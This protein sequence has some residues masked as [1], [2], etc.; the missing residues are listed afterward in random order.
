MATFIDILEQGQVPI[1]LSID[2]MR[3]LH[4]T[5]EHT[6]Q[7]DK[8]TCKA[9]GMIRQPIPVSSS[10][11]AMF[12]LAAFCKQHDARTANKA[13]DDDK[14]NPIAYPSLLAAAY[15][16]EAASKEPLVPAPAPAAEVTETIGHVNNDH[17]IINRTTKELHRVHVSKRTSKTCPVAN[18]QI[19]NQRVT[20]RFH[21]E[22]KETLSS[23]EDNF[24]FSD[25]PLTAEQIHTDKPADRIIPAPGRHAAEPRDP[26]QPHGASADAPAPA[27]PPVT[28]PLALRRIHT[29]LSQPEELRKLHLQHH[30][31]SAE[32]FKFRT[33][34]LHLPKEIYDLYDKIRAECEPCQKAAVA[35]SRS[36][37]SGLRAETF[38]EL[39]FIDHCQ[40]LL[41]TGEHIVV[42]VILDGATTLLTTEVVERTTDIT[43]IPLL[44]N[45][46]DQCHPQPKCV[47]GDQAFMTENWET[48]YNS[49]DIRPIS[50]G[51][52][53]HGRTERR[54][55]YV[56]SRDK[57]LSCSTPSRQA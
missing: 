30:H 34:A 24:T 27:E 29:R 18:T 7:C 4:M 5:I 23:I 53:H 15:P 10:G 14:I 33:R 45:Y 49:L 32:Q 25:K 54:P 17:W 39:T 57:S 1:L 20:K 41:G 52:M 19:Y 2:Q 35:P 6:P 44:R 47:V 42:L 28:L 3:N 43:N 8:I 51:P 55:Q 31:M 9:F 21:P 48:F 12:D 36:K 38:G 56:S 22:T 26:A 11:Q 16:A 13:V 40:V 37:T 46:F 50:L